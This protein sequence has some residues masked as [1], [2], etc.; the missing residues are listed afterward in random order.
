LSL[1]SL[2]RQLRRH[3]WLAAAVDLLI[4]VVGVF[5]GIQVSNWN[6]D[7][8]ER[9]AA[10]VYIE[11]IRQ[12][13]DASA[14]SIDNMVSYYRAIRAHALAALA[15]FDKPASELGEPFLVDA[16]QATQILMRTVERSTYDELLSAGAMNSIPDV[17]VRRRLAS[18]YKNVDAI[19]ELMRYI[20]PYRENLRR[21][22]PYAAQSA[23]FER[24]DDVATVDAHGYVTT[25]L[26]A[27]CRPGLPPEVVASAV[28]AIRTQELRL[29]LGRRLTDLDT[30]LKNYQRLV[31]RGQVLDEFLAQANF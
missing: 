1:R 10:H 3:D 18:Y 5:I 24:C 15:A 7:R 4:V 16:Y 11:R 22:M 19:E 31:D 27:D 21:Q 26:P 28:A 8:L 6:A 17:E 20:P 30:K 29:D 13:I 9:R 2:S 25:T 23:I 14:H 12:D